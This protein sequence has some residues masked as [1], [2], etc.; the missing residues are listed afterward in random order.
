MNDAEFVQF[1]KG[2]LIK[3][4]NIISLM[5]QDVPKH[6]PAYNKVLGVQQKL[7]G[8]DKEHKSKMF[9]Q[10]ITTRAIVNYFMNGRYQDGFAQ[11]LKLKKELCQFCF[12]IENYERD[13]NKQLPE[14]TSGSDNISSCSR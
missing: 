12:Q 14:K 6:I 8:L 13:T 11:V 2:T 5:E 3:I 4:E 7:S 9:P 1:L 10:L